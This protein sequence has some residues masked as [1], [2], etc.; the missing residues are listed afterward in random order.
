MNPHVDQLF[1]GGT[2]QGLRFVVDCRL[3][4]NQNPLLDPKL[5]RSL[6]TKR[7]SLAHGLSDLAAF[8]G[9]RGWGCGQKQA[10]TSKIL[11]ALQTLHAAV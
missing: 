1:C 5:H 11:Q 7:N 8:G 3:N 9:F 6:N 10:L 4:T 2:P